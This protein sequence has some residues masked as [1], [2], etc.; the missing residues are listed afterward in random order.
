MTLVTRGV[1]RRAAQQADSTLLDFRARAHGFVF[2]LGQLG[3]GLAE[4][5]R[6]I[7][8][9]Q[10]VLEVY[11]KAPNYSKQRIVG[12][13]DRLDL[14][15][16]IRYH[17]DH[18]GVVQNNFADRIRLGHGDEVRDV[19]H[20]LAPQGPTLYDY[21]LVDSITLELPRREV[22]VFE[23][24]VRP[25][26]FSAP[27]VVGSLYFDAATAELVI[28]RF[29]FTR[30]AY[31]DET[32]EDITIVLE[33]GLWEGRYWLPTRQEIEIRRRTKWLDLPA[34]GII[35]GRWEIQDYAFNQGLSSRLFLGPEIVAAPPAVRDTF[36]WTVPIE[37]AIREVAGPAMTFDLE[38]V[39]GQITEMAGPHVLSGLATARP[40]IGSI[41]EL[42]HF[43]KVEGLAPGAG[44][45]V[46]PGGGPVEIRGWA[47]FGVSDR[48]AKGRLSV[49]YTTGAV[50]LTVRGA[51]QVRDV[52]DDP[53]VAPALNSILA[54]EAGKDYGHYFLSEGADATVRRGFGS[55]GGLSLT[56]GVQ[57]TTSLE[58]RATAA[59]G[60]FD[61]NP[62][63]GS[64]LFGVGRLALQRRSAELAVRGGISGQVV[65]E[66]GAGEGVQY[67]RLRGGGR[68]HVTLGAT[69][70]LVRG[71]AGWGSADLPVH[72]SFV[73]GGRA[74]LVGEPFRA[75]GG[76][77]AAL[78]TVEWQ[79]PVPFFAIPLG[80]FASTGREIVLAPFVA[81][82]WA[83]GGFPAVPWQPSDGVRP[84]I[85]LGVEWFHRVL[86]ADVG[87]SL[88]GEGVGVTVGL[89]RDLWGIL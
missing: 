74:T 76:R 41:S 37:A 56:A 6:L 32:L 3:E 45:V 42:L 55:R 46:R 15:T 4:P 65:V 79:V 48:R 16:D 53:V 39:R 49:Q 23:V 31:L 28:F 52:G 10:L 57:R 7:K 8:S 61:P 14:P 54:Q 9:D 83:G 89:R 73:L 38:D 62:P 17:R 35:R 36:V 69:R 18:L 26:D 13:R 19:P 78:G 70:V 66:A 44:W 40:G 11:W 64:G 5:P 43:N 85:G 71:W 27:R 30:V 25:K 1:A 77:Y 2:F 21:A 68:A 72:R 81:A 47:S 67:L 29:S 82:G 88:R 20:P 75:W 60:T 33:N 87:V 84:V 24:L 12:W 50:T 80:P 63:L 58:V 22:R 59:H 34:R 86:R 51:R